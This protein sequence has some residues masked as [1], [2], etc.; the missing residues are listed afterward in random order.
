M[1]FSLPAWY[2]H[3]LGLSTAAELWALPEA[4]VEVWLAE[5]LPPFWGR[6]GRPRPADALER[7]FRATDLER[8][9]RPKSPFQVGGA[10]AVGTGTLR[11]FAL[12]HTLRSA[13]FR[14]WP[15][16]DPERPLAVEIWPRLF[17]GRLNKS[18]LE[19]RLAFLRER[20]WPEPAARTD[21]AFDAAVSAL[22][23][24]LRAAELRGLAPE[25]D[26]LKRLEGRIWF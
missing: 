22:S 20:G 13:G 1:A 10:G 8:L 7:G 3:R 5:C 9:G 25:P 4:T 18:R 6:P 15:F 23:M 21:D 2:L 11:G 12:L 26:P 24:S 14:I 17:M 16:D 19:H